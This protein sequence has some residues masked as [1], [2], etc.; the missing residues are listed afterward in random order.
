MILPLNSNVDSEPKLTKSN[1][2]FPS[3]SLMGLPV[4]LLLI[5]G[6]GMLPGYFKGGKWDWFTEK[7]PSNL[8]QILNIEKKGL[9]VPNWQII[10]Q[11]RIDIGGKKWL[12]QIMRKEDQEIELLIAPQP[13]Y[14]DKP[15]VEWSDLAKANVSVISCRQE[16]ANLADKSPQNLGIQSNVGK[17]S[18]LLAQKNVSEDTLQKVV[19]N[20]SPSCQN[21][22]RI[23]TTKQGQK[24]LIALEDYRDWHTKSPQTLTFLTNS[25]QSVTAMYMKGWSA[26]KTFAVVN[27][28]AW[29]SGGNFAPPQW[30][31]QDLNAQLKKDRTGWLAVSLRI[32]IPPNTEI[33]S[34]ETEAKNIAQAIQNQLRQRITTNQSSSVQE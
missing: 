17:I 1:P 14:R 33:E 2:K 5:L 25:G 30:F 26:S 23:Q 24:V 31:W 16:I 28:Y 18:E 9:P 32:P 13:F 20:L 29:E 21:L 8:A 27:W 19:A 10:E 15:A 22:L 4:F 6:I 3:V 7:T 11:S 12:R 34:V